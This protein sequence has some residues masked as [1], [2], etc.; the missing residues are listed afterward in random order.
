MEFKHQYSL[1]LYLL[2]EGFKQGAIDNRDE[3]VGKTTIIER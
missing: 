2:S 1:L 3:K